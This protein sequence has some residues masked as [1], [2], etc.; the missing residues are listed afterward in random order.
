VHDLPPGWSLTVDERMH[1]GGGPAPTGAAVFYREDALLRPVRAFNDRGEEVTAAVQA[2]DGVA[3]PPG[4]L[5]PRFLG[6]LAADH[7]LTLDFGRVINPPGSTPVLKASGW[8]EYP[9]SQTL[10]SAWQAG[11]DYRAPSL[12]AF[13]D[14][15]WHTVYRQ[16]GYPAGMPREMSLPLDALPVATTQ[17]RIRGNWEVYWDSV[18]VIHAEDPPVSRAQRAQAVIE[19]RVAKT[20][21]ARRDTLAQRRPHYDYQD[22]SPFWDTRTPTGLYT[23]LGPVT[24]LVAA[25]NDAFAIIG[26]GEEIHLEFE[27]PPA[28]PAGWRRVLVLEVRGYAKDMDLYTRDGERVEPLPSTPGVGSVEAR[29]ALHARYLTRFRGG[30]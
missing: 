14:G 30:R 7:V 24:E 12:E 5:D 23:A 29:E 25:A 28:P 20:G 22:R 27:A 10:F 17:L 2:A 26:P 18:A 9:Y 19:A 8:V 16:F 6:R 15:R 21:F 3:A 1:S 13:A 4:A 11:A